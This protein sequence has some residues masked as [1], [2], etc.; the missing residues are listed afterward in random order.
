MDY[1]VFASFDEVVIFVILNIKLADLC[2]SFLLTFK[3]VEKNGLSWYNN[4]MKKVELL[5]PAGNFEKLKVAISNG[6]DAVY[7]G[8]EEFNAR[9]NEDNFT[10]ETLKEGIDYAHLFG[11][12]VYLALNILFKD[13]EMAEALDVAGKA[14]SYGVDAIIVQDIALARLIK[15]TYPNAVLH[16]STQMGCSNLESAKFLKSLGFSR[17][18]LARETGLEDIKLIKN[19]LDIEIEYF[20]Q[21]ALCVSYS[22]NCYLCA[23]L[24]DASGNR[25]KCKQYCRLQSKLNGN[26]LNKSGYLLSTKDICMLKKL[27]DLA[28]AGVDSLKIEGRARR[29]AY[30]GR[31]TRVYRKALDNDFKFDNDDILS[32]KKVFNRGD[33]SEGYLA[34]EKMIYDK[35][36]NHIGIEIGYVERINKGKRFNEIFISSSHEIIRGDLLKF[37]DK[38]CVERGVVAVDD[39]KSVS[40]NVY[41]VTS[42]FLPQKGDMVRLILD[43]KDD[44]QVLNAK[45]KVVFDGEFVAKVGERAKLT[46]SS[47]DSSI[48]ML[49][50][51]L[52]EVAKSSPLSKEEVKSCLLKLGEPFELNNFS[53]DIENVFMVKSALNALR[54]DAEQKLKDKIIQDYLDKNN[55]NYQKNNE[56]IELFSKKQTQKRYL[57]TSKPIFPSGFDGY[58]FNPENID[59][60]TFLDIDFSGKEIYLVTPVFAT[61]KEVKKIKEILIKFPKLGIYAN[62]YYALNL[63]CKNKTIVGANLNVFNSFSVNFYSSQGFENI[64]LTKENLDLAEIKN[65]GSNLIYFA[66]YYPEYM[67]FAHCPIKEHVGGNCS[68][69]KYKHGYTYKIAGKTLNLIRH[70][71]IS[72]HF[73]LKDTVLRE[74]YYPNMSQIIEEV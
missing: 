67:N 36:Q 39:S 53:C 46:L 65:S 18:V 49:S 37:F 71:I 29:S 23:L 70:K 30:V 8:I 5:A 22:G 15:L 50:E 1:K 9:A 47:G 48:T 31:A 64:V 26:G 66:S 7:L 74:C 45:R 61:E 19:N 40:K 58:I 6:A 21:G 44:D 16:A 10:L 34:G 17:I 69:C 54:R 25:G 41:R 55:L 4:T 59:E 42:T 57:M 12:K 32:L 62:N 33:Y 72:C 20:V 24:A 35:A 73:A 52:L 51:G 28:E 13:E 2:P 14:L 27:K 43:S 56:K 60:K 63:T 11:V 38:D 68:S 3:M